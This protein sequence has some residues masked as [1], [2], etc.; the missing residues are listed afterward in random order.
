MPRPHPLVTVDHLKARRHQRRKTIDRTTFLQSRLQ[1][2]PRHFNPTIAHFMQTMPRV[3]PKPHRF[4]QKPAQ[5][6]IIARDRESIPHHLKAI[7]RRFPTITRR[8]RSLRQQRE[9]PQPP[10]PPSPRHAPCTLAP[11]KAAVRRR[12]GSRR[13]SRPASGDVHRASRDHP[14]SRVTP[15]ASRTA[16]KPAVLAATGAPRF[17]PHVARASRPPPAARPPPSRPP[18]SRVTR[19]ARSRLAVARRLAPQ[20]A[21]RAPARARRGARRGSARARRRPSR[22]GFSRTPAR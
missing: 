8:F 5:P 22:S 4:T 1:T 7:T 18:P 14:P 17:P 2:K 6:Q 3:N 11:R 19:V 21:R 15:V 10:R 20:R 13:G 12:Q 9:V 16:M